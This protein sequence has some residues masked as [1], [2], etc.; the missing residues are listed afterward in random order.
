VNDE[1]ER[2]TRHRRD[3]GGSSRATASAP[4]FPETAELSLDQD[5]GLTGRLW[6][7][8]DFPTDEENATVDVATGFASLGF[9]REALRRGRRI[10]LGLAAAGLLI[11]AAAF[12]KFPPAYQGSATVLLANN[13]FEVP[14]SAILDDQAVAQSRT[15][16]GAAA[17]KLG[18]NETPGDFSGQYAVTTLTDRVLIITAKAAS[19]GLA[20][21]EA[22]A[23]ASAY[24]AFQAKQLL[25]Q[26]QLVSKSLQQQIAQAQ[27]GVNSIDAQI[28][29][30]LSQPPSPTRHSELTRLT[31]ER[32]GA[33]NALSVLKVN[34]AG[35]QATTRIQTTNVIKG[36]LILDPAALLP[37]HKSKYLLLYVGGGLL[38][39]LVLGL[40]IVIIRALVSNRLRRRDDVARALGA[41]VKLSVG[42]IKQR[43]GA[44]GLAAVESTEIQHI[45][46]HLGRAVMP[47]RGGVATLA[48]VPVD[49]PQ[50]AALSVVSLALSCAQ[51]GLKVIVADLCA[52]SPAARLLGADEPGVHTVSVHD[53]HLLAALPDP[54]DLAPE[55]P[56]RNRSRNADAADPLAAACASADLLLTLA[57]VDPST[58][59][60]HLSGWA[61]GAVVEVTAGRSTATRI[62]AVGELI[63][64]SGTELI[65]AVL[66]GADK[67]DESLGVTDLSR[68]QASARLGLRS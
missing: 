40:L 62:H 28:K 46:Q 11:G 3:P 48:V 63:R 45:A 22:N 57:S 24:L 5:D 51:E 38:G 49:D 14:S 59:A 41:P 66:I 26:E 20:L 42:K 54:N 12:V 21:R 61:R 64:L 30:T 52:N 18:L 67:T 50:V 39:G 29:S 33:N 68:P 4:P 47:S 17:H 43:R 56:L 53:A 31:A 60:E 35:Q 13:P 15:V 7:F 2:R 55:G 16:A 32:D 65:S 27:Q 10:W 25:N 44:S 23:V 1:E 9:I 58:G 19:P 6:A 36:S 8:G 34:V 37:Q